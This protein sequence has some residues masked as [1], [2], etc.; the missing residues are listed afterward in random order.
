MCNLPQQR[1]KLLEAFDSQTSKSQDDIQSEEEISEESIRGKS[2]SQTLHF[3]LSFKIFNHNVHNCLIDSRASSNV[4]SLSIYK[5]INGKP[6]PSSCKMIQLD[7]TTVKV[8]GEMK[9]VLIRLSA[10]E[11]VCQFINIMVVD[12]LEAYGL[13]L[14]Q[15]WSVKL[16]DTSQLTGH[17]CGFLIRTVKIISK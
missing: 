15:Y 9:G 12:I 10:D 2:K 6:T 5:R 4:M 16:K 3:L 17:I 1:K 7:R 11:R 14:S 8:V 13:I